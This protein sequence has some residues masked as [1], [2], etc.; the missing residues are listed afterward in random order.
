MTINGV[1]NFEE[2]SAGSHNTYT[3]VPVYVGGTRHSA[4]DA[5]VS[6]LRIISGPADD[7]IDDECNFDSDCGDNQA[8]NGGICEDSVC[9]PEWVEIAVEVP[10][11]AGSDKFR[12]LDFQSEIYAEY[13]LGQILRYKF[14]YGYDSNAGT[15]NDEIIF[16]LDSPSEFLKDTADTYAL[17]IPIQVESSSSG[18]VG[19]G[20]A[21][22]CKA[23]SSQQMVARFGDTCWGFTPVSDDNR[24]C[25]CNSGSWTGNG[26]YYGGWEPGTCNICGCWGGAMAGDKTNGQQKGGI[27]SIGLRISVEVCGSGGM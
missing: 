2:L 21:E 22:F 5:T 20:A 24:G 19:T 23:C 1:Q 11:D 17:T 14:E 27:S 25:G 12:Y 9:V 26:V 16:T 8:C 13:G 6:N 15:Y 3:G 4:A 7:C 18:I 10:G